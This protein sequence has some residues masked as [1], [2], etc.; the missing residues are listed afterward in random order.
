VRRGDLIFTCWGTINQVGLIDESA[1]YDKYVI[2]N[3]QMKLTPDLSTADSEFLYYLFSSPRMQ[4][5]I[6]EGSIGS[7]IPG[8]NLTRLRSLEINLPPLL[9]QKRIARAIADAEGVEAG[10]GDAISKKQAIK[11]GMMQELLTGNIRLPGF[12]DRWESG[13]TLGSICERRTGYWG[14]DEPTT[15]ANIPVQVIRAGDISSDGKL[16]G[17]AT[18]Y[19]TSEE[20]KKAAC[21]ADDVVITASGNGLGKTFYVQSTKILA[22]SNFVRILRPKKGVSGA[23]V[24]YVMQSRVAKAALETH[25]A[26]SAYPNLLPTFFSDPWVSL[27]PFKEQRAIAEV[28]RAADDELDALHAH[29]RKMRAIKQGMM[30]ELLTGYTRL[31]VTE[32]AI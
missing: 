30:Q 12:T 20:R 8:F 14:T 21:A 17:S 6:V 1:G 28:I 9:E 4:R 15:V 32:A 2:S 29:L 16:I 25:T 31:R 23:F 26:T 19:F 10:L 5:E 22:A 24:A 18:R 3:K 7:S 27:P 11:Q 13:C